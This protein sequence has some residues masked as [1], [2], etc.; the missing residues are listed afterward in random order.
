[1][2]L[3]LLRMAAACA[4]HLI[5]QVVGFVQRVQHRHQARHERRAARGITLL[6]EWLSP[7]QK[8]QYEQFQFFDVVGCHSGR[9]YRVQHGINANIIELDIC[10]RPTRGWCFVP[11]GDL[12]PGDVM[13]AQKI[14][15]ETDERGAIAVAKRFSVRDL[16]LPLSS[17]E[18]RCLY[19]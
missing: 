16:P 17:D 18:F 19:S 10:G 3:R 4:A 2:T 11:V 6:R 8:S 15:I 13:L 9:S 1:M 5:M 12:V 14:A 7:E